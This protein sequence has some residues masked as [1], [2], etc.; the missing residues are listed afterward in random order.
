MCH[1]NQKLVHLNRVL[2]WQPVDTCLN[3]AISPVE[4]GLPLEEPDFLKSLA[5]SSGAFLSSSELA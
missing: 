4:S 1:H 3:E 2:L 5:T